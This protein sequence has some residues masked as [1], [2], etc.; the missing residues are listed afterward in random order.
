MKRSALKTHKSIKKCGGS[1]CNS[2]VAASTLGS[3]AFFSGKVGDDTDSQLYVDDLNQAGVDFHSAGQD[4]GITGKCLVMV[5][6][7]CDRTMNTFLGASET[8]SHK[9]I[10]LEALKNSEWFLSRAIS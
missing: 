1:V 4:S 5:T 10:D 2:V 7:D 9:E 3:K 8:L 6:Q